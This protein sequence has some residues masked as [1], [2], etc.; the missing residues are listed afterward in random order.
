MLVEGD[1]GTVLVFDIGQD[2]TTAGSLSLV[3]VAPGE[4]PVTW[5]DAADFSVSGD[6]IRYTTQSGD[7]SKPGTWAFQIRATIGTWSGSSKPVYDI[8][9]PRL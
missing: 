3:A 4:D 2:A 7:L 8:V 6:T 9:Y 5:S 1:V